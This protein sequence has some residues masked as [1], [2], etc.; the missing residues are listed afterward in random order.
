MSER[1]SIILDITSKIHKSP[2]SNSFKYSV[3]T[4]KKK[5]GWE[6]RPNKYSSFYYKGTLFLFFRCVS[7][8]SWSDRFVHSNNMLALCFCICSPSQLFQCS[9]S[10]T[11]TRSQNN[12]VGKGSQWHA[13]AS[14]E[15]QQHRHPYPSVS[16]SWDS[17]T[18]ICSHFSLEISSQTGQ[19][20]GMLANSSTHQLFEASL[21]CF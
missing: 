12:K 13:S 2:G 20:P 5:G 7:P 18:G 9:T 6:T 10:C 14:S 21:K 8:P 11:F 4:I 1:N 19:V 17:P 3:F 16:S 15:A